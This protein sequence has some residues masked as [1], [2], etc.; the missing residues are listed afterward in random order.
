MK[1][2]MINAPADLAFLVER[3]TQA[4]CV[5]LDTEFVWERTYYPKLGVVQVGFSQEECFL[6]DVIAI[7]D[8]APLGRLLADPAVTKIIHDAQQD[9]TILRRVTGAYPQKVFDTRCAAGFAGL[10]ASISLRDLVQ[11]VAGIELEKTESRTDWLRRPLSE[12]QTLYA[13]EDVR[14]LPTVRDRLLA[15]AR[16]RGL[17]AWLLE[18]LA[19]YDDSDSYEEKDPRVQ[20]RRIKAAKRLSARDSAILRE[21]AAWR[22]EEACRRDRPRGHVVPDGTLVS[23]AQRKPR[24]ISELTSFKGL[25]EREVLR[26]GGA[27]LEVLEKGLAATVEERP[28]LPEYSVQERTLNARRTDFALAYLKRKSISHGIDPQLVASRSE[29]KAFIC[30]GV[31]ATPSRHRLLRGWR[32]LFFGE[33]LLKLLKGWHSVRA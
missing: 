3:A 7:Q 22:E 27:I 10:S 30:E 13:I 23:L 16:D 1:D 29:V 14:Y 11:E 25:S 4:E 20:F 8:I 26:S 12:R 21:L 24:L 9:L 5:A 6:I 2:N 15:R 18:E 28:P 33:E 31:S 32:R 17:E 19:G